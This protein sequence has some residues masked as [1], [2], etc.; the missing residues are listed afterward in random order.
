MQQIFN[1]L[2]SL[3]W[4]NDIVVGYQYADTNRSQATAYDKERHNIDG[5]S[6]K[7]E[8]YVKQCFHFKGMGT[9]NSNRRFGLIN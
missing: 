8:V 4:D 5:L 3:F 9:F 7:L 2:L 1:S 6:I